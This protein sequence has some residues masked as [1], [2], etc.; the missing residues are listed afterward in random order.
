MGGSGATRRVAGEIATTRADLSQRC[1][2]WER[3]SGCPLRSIDGWLVSAALRRLLSDPGSGR[4]RSKIQSVIAPALSWMT[5]R[6]TNVELLQSAA[7]GG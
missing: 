6:P 5:M 7:G 1:R 4:S 2:R 3:S